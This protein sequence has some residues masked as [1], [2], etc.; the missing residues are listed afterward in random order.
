MTKKAEATRRKRFLAKAYE[1]L[2]DMK[3]KLI[4]ES[5]ATLRTEREGNRDDCLDSSDLASEEIWPRVEHH[6][7]RARADQNRAD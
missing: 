7:F 4:D 2:T 1:R 6:T 5:Q 3:A